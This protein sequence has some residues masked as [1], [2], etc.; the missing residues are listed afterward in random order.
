VLSIASIDANRA[1]SAVAITAGI[2]TSFD[3][4]RFF[5]FAGLPEVKPGPD[6]TLVEGDPVEHIVQGLMFP[7][8][9]AWERANDTMFIV[10]QDTPQDAA[11]VVET[12]PYQQLFAPTVEEVARLMLIADSG[13]TLL[14]EGTYIGDFKGTPYLF[15]RMFDPRTNQ[16]SVSYSLFIDRGGEALTIVSLSAFESVYEQNREHFDSILF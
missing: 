15:K 2:A 6:V 5:Q 3:D 8:S 4:P 9:E 7:L 14:L 11:I 10:A 16:V 12:I 13:V 1:A